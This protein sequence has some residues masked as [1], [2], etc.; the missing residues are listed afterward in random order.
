MLR[1]SGGKPYLVQ[2][3]CIHAVNHMLEQERTTV[4]AQD[5]EA[6][7]EMARTFAEDEAVSEP[8]TA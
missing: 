3:I 4:T 1:W 5:V 2:K 8:V 7:R 6:A